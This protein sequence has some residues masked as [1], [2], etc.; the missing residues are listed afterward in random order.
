MQIGFQ[1]RLGQDL[2]HLLVVRTFWERQHMHR[3]HLLAVLPLNV[4]YGGLHVVAASFG[5]LNVYIVI[6]RKRADLPNTLGRD[7]PLQRIVKT[8]SRF[9]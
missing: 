2:L 1:T 4:V 8:V 3:K 7:P 5:R 6:K 9:L